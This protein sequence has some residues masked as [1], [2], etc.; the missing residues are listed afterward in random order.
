M[1]HTLIRQSLPEKIC[2]NAVSQNLPMVNSCPNFML[3]YTPSGSDRM[4]SVSSQRN[5]SLSNHSNHKIQIPAFA[6]K[7]FNAVDDERFLPAS[8]RVQFTSACFFSTRLRRSI[9]WSIF[10]PRDSRF[11]TSS[12]S[13]SL[14]CFIWRFS[15]RLHDQS[16]LASSNS[17]F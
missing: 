4:S 7:T 10:F 16:V 5:S 3:N 8:P 2:H 14:F 6:F 15:T 17:K 1:Y 12:A 11:R 13:I 9:T